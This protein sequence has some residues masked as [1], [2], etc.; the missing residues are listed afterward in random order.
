LRV[1]DS[2]LDGA[3]QGGAAL[4]REDAIVDEAAP[5][6]AQAAAAADP[7]TALSVADP[8]V[9]VTVAKPLVAVAAADPLVAAAAA[10]PLVA[11]AAAD[12]LVAAAAADPL[13]AVTVAD[14]LMAAAAAG[15][16]TAAAKFL[17]R[18]GPAIWAIAL[19]SV[20]T[21]AL[22]MWKAMAFARLGVWRRARAHR[23]GAPWRRRA[24]AAALTEAEAGAGPRARVVAAALRALRSGHD[25]RSGLRGG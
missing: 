24:A 3:T 2:A 14:P 6:D 7:V 23:A 16:L 12:P 13:V 10:D 18:G 25:R 11:A 17:V 15:P 9:A 22:I 20:A 5:I 19:L 8:L 1:G 21:L 4:W